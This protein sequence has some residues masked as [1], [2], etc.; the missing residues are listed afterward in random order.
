MR[1]H[2]THILRPLSVGIGLLGIVGA[3]LSGCGGG[4]GS[5]SSGGGATGG[6]GS[7]A[8]CNAN[9]A[10]NDGRARWTVL[11]YMNASNNLQPY[12][13][14]NIAQMASIGSDSN[15]NIVV[16]WKQ[17]PQSEITDCTDCVPSFV[18][19]RRYLLHLHDV[20]SLCTNLSDF[21]SCSTNPPTILDGDRLADPSTNTIDPVSNVG[22][23]DMGD[24]H[25][26]ENFVQW[27]LQT[28]P[29][30][31]YALVIWDHGSGWR[32]VYRSA[33]KRTA[34]RAVSQDEQTGNEIETW[35]LPQALAN[36]PHPLDMIIFDCSLEGN[37]EV[38]YQIRSNARVMV[39]SEQSPPGAGYPYQLWLAALKAGGKNPCDLGTSIVNTFVSNYSTTEGQVTQ[40][41]ID[42]SQMGNLATSLNALGGA[43]YNDRSAEASLL[44]TARNPNNVQSY[45]LEDPS[46]YAGLI[47]LYSYA[48]NLKSGTKVSAVSTAATNV[49]S[50]LT[51]PNTGAVIYSAYGP[52]EA[53]SYGLSIYCPD[54]A[55]FQGVATSYSQLSFATAAPNWPKFLAAQ[56]Q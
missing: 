49:Q 8:A 6:G 13:L 12:S 51:A 47:D 25:V 56:T 32:D 5:S 19:T 27:G 2:F 4:G 21:T 24:Y 15:V 48:A 16:Q 28:Y 23:S 35:Q 17:S 29:A 18:G 20:T 55:T 1:I 7:R 33:K 53:G 50:A 10:H 30:D 31:N 34:T 22:T 41:V 46:L 36:P 54:P 26:L 38:A 45:G 14:L 40:A 43:L 9:P 39:G 52:G 37:T 44:A 11:V 3:S 42:L